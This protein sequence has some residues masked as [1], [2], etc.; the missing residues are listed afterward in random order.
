V[1]KGNRQ[2]ELARQRVQRQAA[3]RQ[4]QRRRH[5]RQGLLTAG[6]LVSVLA[7][8]GGLALAGTFSGS[9][10][11]TPVAAGA[12]PSASPSAGTSAS[13]GT[14]GAPP[15]CSYTEA[16]A[17]D[18]AGRNPGLPPSTPTVS[19]V[20]Q[21]TLQTS[22]G[23]L[24]VNLDA[25]KAPCTVNALAYLIGKK[26]Y[27]N[28]VCHRVVT[29]SSFAVLQCGDPTGKGTGG[30]GFTMAE[31]NKPTATAAPTAPTYPKGTVAMAKT[32]APGSTGSQFF[33]V[34]KD[35]TLPGDYTIVGQIVGGLGN[36][37]KII[38]VGTSA[39]SGD[40]PPKV[41]VKLSSVTLK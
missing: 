4:A 12:T 30:P 33:L 34:D 27:D 35:T 41:E 36:L 1:G 38:K 18:T 28:T 15:T 14:P 22:S 37:D 25:A 9:S 17:E 23:P 3:R 32:Q 16:K 19:G 10:K 29:Q 2:R 21:A 24:L 26:F 13:P 20:L 11:P 40:G 7:V 8:V 5:R 31:E 39:A 6:V